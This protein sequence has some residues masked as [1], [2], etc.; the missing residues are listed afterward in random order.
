MLRKNLM[1]DRE[2]WAVLC[3]GNEIR[4]FYSMHLQCKAFTNN[5]TP[6]ID[7]VGRRAISLR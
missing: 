6:K 2:I 7:C 4:G 3:S 5:F 1:R